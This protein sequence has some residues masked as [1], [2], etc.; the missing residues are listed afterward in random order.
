VRFETVDK[1]LMEAF[2]VGCRCPI[3]REKP[4]PSLTPNLST[5]HLANPSSDPLLQGCA[6]QVYADDSTST[7]VSADLV[8]FG[9]KVCQ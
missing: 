5:R 3:S 8:P 1:P 2:V 9:A 7:L 6:I 4:L